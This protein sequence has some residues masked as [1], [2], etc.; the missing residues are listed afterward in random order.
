MIGCSLIPPLPR[1]ER[2]GVRVAILV[3]LPNSLS[4]ASGEGWVRGTFGSNG[5]G[6][7]IALLLR[8]G[9]LRDSKILEL[10]NPPLSGI[11]I[12]S[13]LVL[14]LPRVARHRLL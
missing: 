13:Y 2:V 8:F 6:W 7:P 12:A 10:D 3:P 1:W 9:E 11:L 5:N 4:R 14:I